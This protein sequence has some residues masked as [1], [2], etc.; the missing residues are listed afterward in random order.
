MALS[1][2]PSY[3]TLSD[4][5]FITISGPD[6]I[7]TGFAF[8]SQQ[9]ALYVRD[10]NAQFSSQ[11]GATHIVSDPIP[12]ATCDTPGLMTADDKCKLDALLQTRLG[13]LGF[14]GA[15][16][17]D[18]GGW[19]QGDIILAA[20]T[21]FISLERIGN[22]VR[23]TVDSPIPL[24][25]ACESCNQIFWMQDETD[26]SAVR[27]PSCSGKLPGINGYGELKIYTFPETLIVDSTNAAASLQNKANYPSL[28]F[29]RYDDALSPGTNEFE[30]VLKRNA[31]NTATSEIGWVF[32]PGATAIPQCVWF[33]GL[34][35]VGNLRRFDLDVTS[36]PAILGSLLFR[37][38]LISRH[39]AVIVGFTTNILNTN[40]YSLRL[41]D[42]D[43]QRPVGDA[44]TAKNVWQYIN[45]EAGTTGANPRSLLID[46]AIDLLPVGTLVDLWWFKVG[47][48]GGEDIRRYYFC[49]RPT[50]NP[51][52]LWS[53][54]GELSFGD[55]VV[56]RRE[57]A[58]DSGS[59]GVPPYEVITADRVI[60][61]DTWGVTGIN[62]PLYYYNLVEAAGT[63]AGNINYQHRAEVSVDLP[64]LR[65]VETASTEGTSE[66]PIV[67]WNRRTAGNAYIA[68]L[69]GRPTLDR[70]SPYDFLIRGPIDSFEE[71]YL[72]V[73]GTG[74]VQDLYYVAVNGCDFR[75]LPPFG[76]LRSISTSDGTIRYFRYTKKM[77][78]AGASGFD[79][80]ILA[81][82]EGPY[83]GL[84]GDVLECLPLDYNSHV[85]RCEFGY[86]TVTQLVT[87][88]VKVGRLAMSGVYENNEVTSS[89]DDYVRGLEEGYS[90]SA[91]YS[92]AGTYSGIGAKPDTSPADFVVYDGGATTNGEFWNKIEI[93]VR[94]DQ[95]WVWWN[96]LLI[97]PNGA[98]S[99]QL[100]TPVSI[101]GPYFTI[102][103][104]ALTSQGKY[105]MRMW[106]GASL[107][108]LTVK[109]QLTNFSELRYGQLEIG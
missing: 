106:P 11:H 70:F 48:I 35:A 16:F 20:G 102:T 86:D 87:M 34:D 22:V 88:Q 27:P 17:P 6:G 59:E 95:V 78:G 43:G 39:K 33:M 52:Y 109:S 41:W 108:K 1:K 47:E 76:T 53:E 24:N 56:A 42:I 21:E 100:T 55:V 12:S 104:D 97:P 50:L 80:I 25:C 83:T 29:K 81:G 51:R 15:G 74:I 26:V 82:T 79:R 68:A 96:E 5:Q 84:E 7:S 73:L 28:I 101:S 67:V 93:M 85:V 8:D 103:Q 57:G 13:V 71:K 37:G 30:M 105:G 38:H 58:L 46:A 69:I 45:P 90:V 65:V 72:Y 18:D 19:M 10:N 60:E 64:G 54:M 31:T 94:D 32:T 40:V 36:D 14:Q 23:F 92:Q 98:L 4:G 89:L 2:I 91:V 9:R 75:D 3:T 77:M 62:D 99:S 66:R 61:R 63:G 44:F 49:Q 107:R